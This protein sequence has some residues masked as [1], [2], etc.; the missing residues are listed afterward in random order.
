MVITEFTNG[1]PLMAFRTGYWII[2]KGAENGFTPSIEGKQ[3]TMFFFG[4]GTA[5]CFVGRTV[6]CIQAIVTDHFK[7]LVGDVTD[8]AFYEV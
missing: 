6:T 5:D 4:N 3:N 7:V 2:A 8:E 1:H